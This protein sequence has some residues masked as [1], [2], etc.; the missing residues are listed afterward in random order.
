[1]PNRSYHA[2]SGNA[3]PGD[4][5]GVGHRC[6]P[7]EEAFRACADRMA[8]R[9]GAAFDDLE[10][11]RGDRAR[12][13]QRVERRC[14]HV[15]EVLT[16]DDVR[17][18]VQSAFG[19]ADVPA[20]LPT[21]VFRKTEGNP[22]F[23]TDLVRY[24]RE[25]GIQPETALRATDVPDSLRGLIERMLERFDAPLRQLLSIAAV[26][27]FEFDSATLARVSGA[28][29]AEV[30]ERLRSAA[31]VHAVVSP[32]E[33]R[34]MPDGTPSLVYRFVHVLYQDALYGSIAPSRRIAWA[35]QIAEAL[36]ASHAARSEAIAGQLAVLFETGRDFWQAAQYFLITSRNAV[37]L[38]AFTAAA[39]LAD[40]GLHCLQAAA[41]V[42]DRERLRRELDLTFAK[43]VPLASLQGYGSAEVKPL[44]R[45]VVE[46]GEKVSD[47]AATAAGLAATWI[48]RMVRGLCLDGKKRPNGSSIW[49][50][51]PAATFC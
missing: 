22:L 4:P 19:G 45:R 10:D 8:Q 15:A 28:A 43:L 24:V 27:G 46:L 23:M 14:E 33:E 2:S 6:V 5:L 44:A 18:Y 30:E 9:Q 1:V 40:R 39:E 11:R 20:D 3:A 49:R 36:L 17:S 31:Q 26:Q 16:L 12:R 38:F 32:V 7:A 47:P 48:V 13:R 29:A 34:E 42:D 51:R 25:T 21:F 37:R 35:Q 50:A 41:A